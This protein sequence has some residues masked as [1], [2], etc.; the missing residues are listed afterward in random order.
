MYIQVL[1]CFYTSARENA[2]KLGKFEKLR[3]ESF[4]FR[5]VEN[6]EAWQEI[7]LKFL[8]GCE[9]RVTLRPIVYLNRLKELFI[10]VF[11]ISHIG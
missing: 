11:I 8:I 5:V 1:Q 4:L 10:L 9:L 6:C 3:M 2:K 7:S